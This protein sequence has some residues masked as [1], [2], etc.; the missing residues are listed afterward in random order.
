MVYS[1]KRKRERER[2]KDTKEENAQFT[3]VRC[4]EVPIA[5]HILSHLGNNI[6]FLH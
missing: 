3:T 6:I 2:E 1:Y 5:D 4:N